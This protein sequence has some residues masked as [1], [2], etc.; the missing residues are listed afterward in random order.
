MKIKCCGDSRPGA[1]LKPQ[2]QHKQLCQQLQGAKIT[3]HTIL[4]GVDGTVYTA[5]TLDQLKQTRGRKKSLVPSSGFLIA[6]NNVHASV[7]PLPLAL[8][9]GLFGGALL[10]GQLLPPS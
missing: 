10:S 3:L 9:L 8:S 2:Q 1:Q 6:A 4:L 5:R 7:L